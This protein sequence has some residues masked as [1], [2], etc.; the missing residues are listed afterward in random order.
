[1]LILEKLMDDSG[2]GPLCPTV[3]GQIHVLLSHLPAQERTRGQYED[4]LDSQGLHA[5]KTHTIDDCC[6]D[7]LAGWK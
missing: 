4:M 7:I 1:M 5:I 3:L 6:T 2:T